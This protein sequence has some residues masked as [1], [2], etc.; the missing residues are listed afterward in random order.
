[1]N[2]TELPEK[3]VWPETHYVYVE[4]TGEFEETAPQAWKILRMMVPGI[5]KQNA[6]AGFM[7]LYS[8]DPKMVYAAGVALKGAPKNLADGLQHKIIPSGNFA[9]FTLIGSYANL[10]NA[11]GQVWQKISELVSNKELQ[12]RSAPNIENYVNDPETTPE[13]EL[14]TEILFPIV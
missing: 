8:V 1:M 4:K 5:M 7:S 3:V 13:D 11:S 10:G 9:K 6:I 14:I 2:L 12:L